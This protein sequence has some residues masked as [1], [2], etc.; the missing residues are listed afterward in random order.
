MVLVLNLVSRK[1]SLNR[2]FLYSITFILFYGITGCGSAS[3]K[4]CFFNAASPW[5]QSHFPD[6]QCIVYCS[7]GS[8]FIPWVQVKT[9]SP[10]EQIQFHIGTNTI[11]Q[12]SKYLFHIETN[13]I[14]HWKKPNYTLEQIQF[15]FEINSI[16]LWNK[17]NF[18]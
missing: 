4:L 9:M 7:A 14:L 17:S 16:A 3:L 12:W 8:K 10:M 5:I 11:S 18:S 15:N 1:I 2:Q 6:P 13:L